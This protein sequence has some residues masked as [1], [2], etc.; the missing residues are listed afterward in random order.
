MEDKIHL[1][2]DLESMASGQAGRG[3]KVV[4]RQRIGSYIEYMY[5]ASW[6]HELAP[7][8]ITLGRG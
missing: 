7:D 8:A 3:K 6:K 2:S 1:K 5:D 4:D